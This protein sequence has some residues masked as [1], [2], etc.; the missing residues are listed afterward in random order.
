[1][2]VRVSHSNM[3]LLICAGLIALTLVGVSTLA[4]APTTQQLSYL[5]L[6]LLFTVLVAGVM[7]RRWLQ[8]EFDW[9]EPGV[10]IAVVYLIFFG[11]AGL[12]YVMDPTLLHPFLQADQGWL[13][14]ALLFVLLG[15]VAFWAGYYG[16]LG[17]ALHRLT[18]RPAREQVRAQATIRGGLVVGLYIV[19]L[20][21]RLIMLWV[22]LYGYLQDPES[23]AGVPYGQLFVRLEAFCSY[24]LVLAW[25]DSYSRPDHKLRRWFAWGL[26]FFEMF[27]GFFSGMKMNVILP[28]LFVAMIHTYKRAR[29]PFR[30][31]AVAIALV[32]LIYPVNTVY[33]QMVRGGDL[34]IRSPVD[35]IASSPRLVDEL[36]LRY[37][38]PNT[39]VET[40][41]QSTLSRASV[42]QSYALLLK[43][44]DHTGD[45]WHGRYF[46]M[47]PALIAVP[48]VVWPDK[49]VANIGY[50]FA[51][52]VWGQDPHVQSSVAITFPGD[53]HLQFGLPSLLLGMFLMGVAF[54]W[55]YE[56]YARPCTNYS[57]FFYIFLLYHL[58]AHETDLTFKVAG[59][60]RVFLILFV[61]SLV[62]FRFP[63]RVA[64]GARAQPASLTPARHALPLPHA[65]R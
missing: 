6:L 41:Y 43:Y 47:L 15:I 8:Q 39:Y 44:L 27:W 35:M 20:T 17:L 37:D 25:L 33:R 14:L 63:R 13:T 3:H 30:Y 62:V 18:L 36:L 29:L 45:Y 32:V 9:F 55:L 59:T 24:A 50:W 7:V 58:G 22:G 28:L 42:I 54:R 51:V 5:W 16:R 57:I 21:A 12:R 31:V 40:G 34:E 65:G 19:G 2:R 10:F 56:R 38:D 4:F 11:F 53:L 64:V 1:M 61:V 49:P 52:N 23:V 26:L 48:R 46:W 60:V